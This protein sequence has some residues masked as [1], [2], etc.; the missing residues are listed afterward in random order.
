MRHV[1]VVPQ[2]QAGTYDATVLGPPRC[3]PEFIHTA[4]YLG[5]I[6]LLV[7][8]GTRLPGPDDGTFAAKV[9]T[10]Y[11]EKK[12]TLGTNNEPAARGTGEAAAADA[13]RPDT[14]S[15]PARKPRTGTRNGGPRGASSRRGGRPGG[16]GGA[17]PGRG[18]GGPRHGSSG[19]RDGPPKRDG[20]RDGPPKRD[21]RRG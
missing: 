12:Y 16:R 14:E 5:L 3:G 13:A 1:V 6:D 17:R 8:L 2:R 4:D 7:A 9:E 11:S 21:G 10:M 19:R 15:A 18:A 20:R